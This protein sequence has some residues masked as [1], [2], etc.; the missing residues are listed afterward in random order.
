MLHTI[1]I[2]SDSHLGGCTESFQRQ[3]KTAFSDCATILHAGDLSDMAVL[4]AFAGKQVYAVHGNSCNVQSQQTLPRSLLITIAGFRIGLC[5][6]A[7]G[8]RQTIED[9]LWRLFP[10]ADCIVYGHTHQAVCHR[11]GGILYINPGAFQQGS[12]HGAIGSYAILRI[13][14]QAH[15]NQAM[16]AAIHEMPR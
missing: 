10:E 9:R 13:D 8:P 3:V 16:Q 12:P 2:L 5:H 15:R 4:E 6:G 11:L 14:A 7:W 1:G